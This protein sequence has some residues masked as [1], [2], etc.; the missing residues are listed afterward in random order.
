M[1][2]PDGVGAGRTPP[3]WLEPGQTVR[4]SIE[5]VGELINVC[6]ARR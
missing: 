6:S 3:V 4:T 1:G 5:R 2:T